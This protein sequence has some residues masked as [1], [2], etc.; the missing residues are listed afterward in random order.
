MQTTRSNHKRR[1]GVGSTIALLVLGVLMLA[2]VAMYCYTQ[3]VPHIETDLTE[4]VT[5]ELVSNGIT[6]ALVSLDGT[7]VNLSGNVESTATAEEAERL[8]IG[9]YGVT[10]VQNDLNKSLENSTQK[11][12][13][14]TDSAATNNTDSNSDSTAVANQSDTSDLADNN[15][16]AAEADTTSDAEPSGS[17]NKN[18]ETASDNADEQ[19][20][21]DTVSALAISVSDQRAVIS[22]VLPETG[23]ALRVTEA[24]AAIYGEDNVQ[25][26]VSIVP[27][28][29]APD[30]LDGTISVI[31]RIGNINDPTLAIK[32]DAVILGGTVSS[33]T[34]GAQQLSAAKRA[35]GDD[36]KVSATFDI[37]QRASTELPAPA[38]K[39]R[40][41]KKRP[42]SLRIES[43]NDSVRLTGTVSSAEEAD[44]VRIELDELFDT[45]EYTDELIIDD[46]VSGA[47][48]IDEALAVTDSVRSIDNFSVS[49]NSGQ[50]MLS[51]DVQSRDKGKVL[52]DGARQLVNN[53][54][55]VVNNY[56][57]N[58]T[59]LVIESAEE[60][61]ARELGEKLVALE[62][63]KIVFNPGSAELAADAME[64][65]DQ[66]A[67]TI[68][69][70]ADQI[71]EISGHTD[72]SG[73]SVV[74][75]EL[76]KKRAI[77]VRDYL[78]SKGLPSN[79]LR[80]IG[81]GESK[82]VADNTTAAGRAA[83]RRIEFNL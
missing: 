72:A 55:N 62:T 82:P 32:E 34:L 20:P 39:P 43:N 42:A 51:G 22:G 12:N 26:E 75:L 46:S 41:A 83:N 47:N 81:Y 28:I 11:N 24:V 4:R 3:L 2:G 58:Q 25:D 14:L 6:T 74:N 21:A 52:A 16:K 38:G 66:V 48:W 9:V 80:P 64:V 73:D 45:I 15:A 17:D 35:L 65:L 76:S 63:S 23:M 59:E 40:E 31:D 54:L 5:A 79:Q 50:L 29:P 27:G 61:L 8:A 33:E 30:W 71:I 7:D 18:T 60:V 19:T 69:A 53:K 68:S 44:T 70:Y 77:A 57:V 78:V 13:A 10:S 49:I 1:G 56:S 36:M 37:V 67:V